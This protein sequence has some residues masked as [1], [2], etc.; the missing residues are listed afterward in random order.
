[1]KKT[2]IFSLL[3][4]MLIGIVAAA[5]TASAFGWGMNNENRE[6][7][8]QAIE[9]NDYETY[10]ELVEDISNTRFEVLDE[11][12]FEKL[13]EMHQAREDGDFELAHELGEELGHGFFGQGFFQGQGMGQGE[14]MKGQ[15]RKGGMMW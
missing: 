11:E 15:G 13:V 9:D 3:A 1:M 10:K 12:D 14:G 5:G 4:L 6:A 2:T 7:L 8:E